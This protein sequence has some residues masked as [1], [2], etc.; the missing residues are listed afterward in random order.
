MVNEKDILKKLKSICG[1]AKSF[2]NSKEQ[3]L[4]EKESLIAD[5]QKAISDATQNGIDTTSMKSTLKQ[6]G[7]ELNEEE[8]KEED[9][10][11]ENVFIIEASEMLNA[12]YENEDPTYISERNR[13]N[14]LKAKKADIEG[15]NSKY[16][17]QLSSMEGESE[18]KE[19]LRSDIV[20]NVDFIKEL[21]EDFLSFEGSYGEMHKSVSA[22]EDEISKEEAAKEELLSKIT[23]LDS[24]I[25]EV[26]SE[27]KGV[28]KSLVDER[29]NFNSIASQREELEG[30]HKTYG[31]S[32]TEL[33]EMQSTSDD[34]K[35]ALDEI[36]SKEKEI[37]TKLS[38][39]KESKQKLASKVGERDKTISKLKGEKKVLESTKKTNEGDIKTLEG[40]L[41]AWKVNYAEFEKLVDDLEEHVG[42][43]SY[44]SFDGE[45]AKDGQNPL[46]PLIE[47]VQRISDWV[48]SQENI[49]NQDVKVETN[50]IT[51]Y[52]LGA[53]AVG[54]LMLFK[55]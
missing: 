45:E 11:K 44:S 23:G 13:Y 12:L 26:F 20:Y 34:V 53:V 14:K 33:I 52:L 10:L 3:S 47:R 49:T 16:E 40:K 9:I 21:D 36:G 46:I 50:V 48:D 24:E 1:D 39:L 31:I 25:D 55:R 35:N 19:Q 4:K 37:E 27:F 43:P 41:G 6:F 54:A 18:E 28:H 8:L 51:P 42:Y 17:K 38:E 29:M 5:M 30:V 15:L 7:K 2:L 22:F 32:G